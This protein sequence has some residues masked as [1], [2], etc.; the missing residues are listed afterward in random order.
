MQ[1]MAM[2][3][4]LAILLVGIPDAL[5]GWAQTH[6]SGSLVTAM[7]GLIPVILVVVAAQSGFEDPSAALRSLIPAVL[8]LG[9]LLL[10]VPVDLPSST[11]GRL[12][13][14]VLLATALLLAFVSVSIHRLLQLFQPALAVA[15]VCL[16]N[17]LLIP[18]AAG[19]SFW[20]G[21]VA[22]GSIL[23][24]L[25]AGGGLLLFVLLLR[26]LDPVRLGSRY[27]VIPLLTIVEG[28]ILLRPELTFRMGVGAGLL[29]GG[30]A[31][32]LFS[33]QSDEVSSLS[34]R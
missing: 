29:A 30:A 22:S 31:F 3:G 34:L 7:F 9:G 28:Y 18:L 12:S 1:D 17:A 6:V 32:L 15:I 24:A 27:L 33:E 19:R 26:R 14:A 4:G 20:H 10:L 2:L 21:S 13:F 25:A 11:I 8:G 16:A 23:S 5:A